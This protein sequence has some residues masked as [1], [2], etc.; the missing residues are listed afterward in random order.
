[1]NNRLILASQSPRRSDL[2]QRSGYA[3]EVRKFDVVEVYPNGLLPHE[4]ASYLA[5]LKAS[6]ALQQITPGYVILTADTIVIFDDQILG[7]PRDRANAIQTLQ[8]LSGAEHEVITAVSIS[9]NQSLRTDYE[10]SFVKFS[11]LTTQEIHFYVDHFKPYDKAGSYG[12]QD[13]IGLCK[14]EKIVGSYTNIMG[15]PMELTYKMLG[16]FEIYPKGL[17]DH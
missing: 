15:L 9:S 8:L 11:D 12:I 14:I 10:R 13:W 6:S 5:E 17:K 1:M 2:L 3:F 4:V 16:D 7:K